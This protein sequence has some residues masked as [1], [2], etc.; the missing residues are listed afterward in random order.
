MSIPR[1]TYE[2][3][4][5]QWVSLMITLLIGEFGPDVNGVVL[6]SRPW[7][8]IFSVWVRNSKDKENVDN[9]VRHLK[10]LFGSDVQIRFQRHQTSMRKKLTNCKPENVPHQQ[11]YEKGTFESEASSF[12]GFEQKERNKGKEEPRRLVGT[13]SKG[14][15]QNITQ[16]DK[17]RDETFDKKETIISSQTSEIV[18]PERLF[19]EKIPTLKRRSSFSTQTTK[20]PIR[21]ELPKLD[22]LSTKE[23]GVALAIFLVAIVVSIFSW[24]YLY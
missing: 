9:T 21:R 15:L 24:N 16:E 13:N 1:T 14:V 19:I 8:N 3:T 17:V 2:D 18:T 4:M 23:I 20:P 7:G 11:Y 22:D 6:S 10:E 5:K 12:E